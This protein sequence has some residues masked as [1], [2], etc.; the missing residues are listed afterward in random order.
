MQCKNLEL[1]FL[2]FLFLLSSRNRCFYWY[3][4]PSTPLIE[5]KHTQNAHTYQKKAAYARIL[6]HALVDAMISASC[7]CDQRLCKDARRVPFISRRSETEGGLPKIQQL[8]ERGCCTFT[9]SQIS[10]WLIVKASFFPALNTWCIWEFF[11][12]FLIDCCCFFNRDNAKNLDNHLID[13]CF[14]N[15]DNENSN[16]QKLVVLSK[17]RSCGD[18]RAFMSILLKPLIGIDFGKNYE[19]KK[20]ILKQR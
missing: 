8:W 15:T 14:L 6:N 10:S 19:Q 4:D 11:Y 18:K 13:C 9:T 5:W 20:C 16:I 7:L 1:C 2:A 17:V 3:N 12:F